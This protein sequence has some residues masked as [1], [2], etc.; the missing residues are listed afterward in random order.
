MIM[1]GGQCKRTSRRRSRDCAAPLSIVPDL[2]V[3]APTIALTTGK[4]LTYSERPRA[5]A[6]PSLLAASCQEMLHRVLAELL[7]TDLL[8]PLLELVLVGRFGSQIHCLR[9]VE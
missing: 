1:D 8:E 7:R 9:L 3:G 5:V 4:Q 6:R 2:D